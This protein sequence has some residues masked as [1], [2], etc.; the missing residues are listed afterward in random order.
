MDL[1]AVEREISFV[2]E[3]QKY[4]KAFAALQTPEEG[5]I[6]LWHKVVFNSATF[7]NGL[8]TLDIT[9]PDEARLGAGG[10]SLAIDA[11]KQTMFQFDEVQQLELTVD[12]QQVDS[13][14][15]HVELEHPFN[16]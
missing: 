15:G 1:Q 12:G 5:K 14:M 7:S 9:L 2:D 11:L 8:L 3:S 16:K 10:E 4:E 13:L 6:S